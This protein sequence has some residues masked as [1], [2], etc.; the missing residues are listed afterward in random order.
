MSLNTNNIYINNIN[1][2]EILDIN[3]DSSKDEIK[4]A[5]KK[6]IL[7]YHPDKNANKNLSND[8]FIQIK[9]A[10][11]ILSDKD[12]K[13]IYDN[14]LC[15]NN[16]LH[17]NTNTNTNTNTNI[18]NNFTLDNIGILINNFANSSDIEKIVKI[19][20]S[21]NN[22]LL[23]GNLIENIIN[24]NNIIKE[25]IDIDIILNFTLKEVWH[26]I[27][28]KIIY[29]K[30]ITKKEIFEELI[31]PVDLNQVYE[32][33]GEQIKINNII[34]NGNINIKINITECYYNDEK[35]FIYND[36]LYLILNT[37]RILNDRF[38]I[39]FLDDILY[40]FNLKKLIPIQNELGLI[41]MK[42]NFGLLK[43]NSEN[44]IINDLNCV[45]TH[46]NLYF[47]LLI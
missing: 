43:F 3:Q 26:G 11:D 20:L 12:K 44:N 4:K 24:N 19:L 41:Y 7:K 21:K 46:K 38:K 29:D 18:I 8:K 15:I 33:D 16:L 39:Y 45:V 34:Y 28:K 13:K 31:Y 32:N 37:K 5:Y 35:Y 6:L 40:K 17:L 1:L 27:P 47:I 23:N 10:Y 30:R 36:E 25:I 2:Y 14:S 22:I 9:Y 42:K